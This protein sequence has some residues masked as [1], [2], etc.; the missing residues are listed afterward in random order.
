MKAQ[1]YGGMA[2]M[3]AHQ[4]LAEKESDHEDRKLDTIVAGQRGRFLLAQL[5]QRIRAA[6]QRPGRDNGRLDGDTCLRSP[7]EYSVLI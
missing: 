6:A 7:M 5:N 4:R 2:L 3:K 1:N